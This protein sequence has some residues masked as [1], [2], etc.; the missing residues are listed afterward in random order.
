MAGKPIRN[1]QSAA[2]FV[3]WI[4]KLTGMAADWPWWRSEAEK[5]HVLN[6]FREA[7]TVFSNR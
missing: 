1:S 4:D 6:Q 3:R 5:S 7:R 2:Y